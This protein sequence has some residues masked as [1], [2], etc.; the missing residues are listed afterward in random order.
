MSRKTQPDIETD[1]ESI[2]NRT[3]AIVISVVGVVAVLLFSG[4]FLG[5]AWLLTLLAPLTF[6]QAVA[7]AVLVVGSAFLILSRW[8]IFDLPMITLIVLTFAVIALVEVLLARLVVL[9]SP[10]TIWEASLLVASTAALLLYIVVQVFLDSGVYDG[11]SSDDEES[12]FVGRL[13][14][15]MY[16]LKPEIV[17]TPPPKRSRTS[18][19]AARR[20]TDDTDSD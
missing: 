14:P 9:I 19:R 7:M 13:S 10:L 6:A 2:S 11:Y 18:R 8:Q 4:Y 17:E 12:P 20:K 5:L 3:I 15:D 1:V 16:V